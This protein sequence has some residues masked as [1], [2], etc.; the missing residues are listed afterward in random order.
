VKLDKPAAQVCKVYTELQRSY[1]AKVEADARM[2]AGV[3]K[4]RAA[5]NCS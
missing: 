5:S 4:G 2:K 3:A 1:G